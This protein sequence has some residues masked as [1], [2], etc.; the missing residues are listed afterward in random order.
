MGGL[1]FIDP[2]GAESTTV[3]TMQILCY[4]CFAARLIH[5][6]GAGTNIRFIGKARWSSR[7]SAAP[8][9]TGRAQVLARGCPVSRRVLCAREVRGALAVAPAQG[10]SDHAYF[11]LQCSPVVDPHSSHF[12]VR[13]LLHFRNDAPAILRPRLGLK[14]VGIVCSNNVRSKQLPPGG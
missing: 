8:L 12:A 13:K 14:A 2:T 7:L 6:S 9:Q 10:H 1:L 3:R 4:S 5:T 11:H